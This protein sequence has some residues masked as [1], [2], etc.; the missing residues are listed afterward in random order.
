MRGCSWGGRWW[1]RSSRHLTTLGPGSPVPWQ[2]LV[3]PVDGVIV[4]PGEHVG[5]P[6]LRIDVIELGCLNERQHD[7]RALTTAI[8]AGEQP[9]L[10][11]K[12]NSAQFA[13]RCIVG[14]ADAPVL[15]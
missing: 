13:L 12:S 14:E 4:D 15:E 6:C 2:K 10:P 5:E 1:R 9:R 7:R 8:G 3:E 11:P